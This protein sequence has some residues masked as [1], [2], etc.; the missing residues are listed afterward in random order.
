MRFGGRLPWR[1]GSEV[2]RRSSM[3]SIH[4]WQGPQGSDWMDL[5]NQ[6]TE[7]AL[8]EFVATTWTSATTQIMFRTS[9]GDAQVG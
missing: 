3:L 1:H 9:I 6:E 8:R 4:Y 5:A 7:P 2:L